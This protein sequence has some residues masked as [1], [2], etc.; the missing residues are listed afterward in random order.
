MWNLQQAIELIQ[1]TEPIVAREGY[2]LGL[3]GSV[4]FEGESTK[5]LDLIL[6]VHNTHKNRWAPKDRILYICGLLGWKFVKQ[7]D[8]RDYDDDKEVFQV[9]DQNNNRIDILQ[10]Q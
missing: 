1:T 5:D 6:Y 3:T 10:L 8:H 4:L 2:H 7:C 9:T